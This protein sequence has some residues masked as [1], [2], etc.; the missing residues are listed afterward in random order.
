MGGVG[1]VPREILGPLVECR[2]ESLGDPL[3]LGVSKCCLKSVRNLGDSGVQGAGS[4]YLF[5]GLPCQAGQCLGDLVDLAG[6]LGPS[7][8]SLFSTQCRNFSRSSLVLLNAARSEMGTGHHPPLPA[9]RPGR[10]LIVA[11]CSEHSS[12]SSLCSASRMV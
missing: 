1:K 10:A 5:T 11:H 7:P 3:G 12:S 6:E 9:A 4:P 2:E 8:G